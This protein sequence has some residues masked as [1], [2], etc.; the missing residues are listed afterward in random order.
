[1]EKLDANL[2]T[3]FDLNLIEAV[4]QNPVI[5]DRSHYNYKHF[6]RKAQTWKQIAELLGV[7]E[8]KCTKRWKSLRD[9]FAREM[10]LCQESRWRYFKQMQ[11]LVDSIRQY[12][13]SLLGKVTSVQQATNQVTQVDPN[14][15][16]Q[17][18][19][20]TVVD[21]FTQPFN[22][23][24]TTST[25]ALAHPHVTGDTQITV[26][27]PKEQKP[28]F[29]EPVLK[30]ERTEEE[31]NHD[32]MLNTIKIFQNSMTQAVSAEDQS[33]GMVVTDMLN[34]LG[35]RQKAEAKVHI[36]KYLTDMQ[37]LAQHNKY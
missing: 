9:K 15:Q 25:Q 26:A 6:V 21:V 11:F 27:A 34:T 37:L 2:E 7:P 5:Y 17:P 18:Q 22:G 29:Y 20:Q 35:V 28:Y 10:K 1:M 32:N 19:Q 23:T 14:Q 13:E 3:Q 16:Q 8:Q 36:I 33:F 31:N 24:A 12:R 4:K 30:R